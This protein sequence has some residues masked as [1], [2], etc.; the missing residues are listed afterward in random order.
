[1]TTVTLP[2]GEVEYLAKYFEVNGESTDATDTV[3]ILRA[4]LDAPATVDCRGCDDCY[5]MVRCTR[6]LDGDKF[7]AMPIRRHYKVTK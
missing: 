1:M 4:A 7:K 3:K 6:C 5:Q 2:R